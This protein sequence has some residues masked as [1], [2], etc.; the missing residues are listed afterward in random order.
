MR[1]TCCLIAALAGAGCHPQ[2]PQ[3]AQA[4]T[5][6]RKTMTRP[7]IKSLE[8]ALIAQHGPEHRDRIR[9]GVAQVVATWRDEDGDAGE[10]AAFLKAHFIADEKKLQATA[11]HLEYSLE[12]LDGHANEVGRELSR[13]T[14]L[15]EGQLLPVDPLLAAYS[16]SAHITED[17]FRS[18]IAFVVLLNF[19]LTTLDQRLKEGRRWSRARWALARLT[20]RFEFR[21]PAPLLQE[22][23]RVNSAAENYID[24]YNIHMGS[25]D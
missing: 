23:G 22:L 6:E 1:I 20:G 24:N 18:K 5:P 14:Q 10:L 15:E 2:T 9:R 19:P 25:L 13:Y 21:V 12:M 3:P 8:Q 11:R 16:P 7:S 17:L 4:P